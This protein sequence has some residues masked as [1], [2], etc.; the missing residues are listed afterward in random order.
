MFPSNSL[1]FTNIP[2]TSFSMPSNNFIPSSPSETENFE[3]I[4]NLKFIPPDTK[5]FIK[6]FKQKNF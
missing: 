3:E 2:Q 4:P 6:Y 5:V 1:D